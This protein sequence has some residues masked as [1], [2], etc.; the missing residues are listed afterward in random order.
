MS[1]SSKTRKI[2]WMNS[3]KKCAICETELMNG[4]S[5][6]GEECHIVSSKL[7][8]PRH[9]HMKNYDSPKNIIV[10]CPIH[11]K[12][13]DDNPNEYT[14]E[15]LQKIKS[16]H[17]RKNRKENDSSDKIALKLIDNAATIYLIAENS[18]AVYFDYSQENYDDIELFDEFLEYVDN[19]DCIVNVSE[20]IK[21]TKDIFKK[22]IS[23][24]YKILAGKT[25][26]NNLKLHIVYLYI[27]NDKDIKKLVDYNNVKN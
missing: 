19:N 26:D 8:G 13:I 23:K 22:I 16:E 20:W 9:R 6:I 1:I 3:F 14:E 11:H 2:V 4:D 15:K 17:I 24:G 21:Y 18:D 27:Y 10:L 7:N 25:Y 12:I 5:V